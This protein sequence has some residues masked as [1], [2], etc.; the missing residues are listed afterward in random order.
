VLFPY[1]N[2][3]DINNHPEHGTSRWVINFRDWHLAAAKQYPKAYNKILHEV[4]PERDAN[5]RK[6]Y[7]DYWWQYA[8]KRPAMVQAIASLDRCIVMTRHTHTVMP[9]MVSTSQVFSEATVVFASSDHALLAFLSGALHYWWAIE[10]GS[11]IKGDLRYTATDIFETLVRPQFT[12]R[13]RVAGTHLNAYRRNLM[14]TRNMGLTA[15]YNLVHSSDC[16]DEDIVE[17]RRIHEE[18]DKATVEAYGWHDLLDDSGQTLPT[19]P[20]FESFP[21][22]HGIHE[23]DQGPRYT[24]GLLA[25]TEI[26]D[27]LRQ[28]NHQAFADEVHLG[29]HKKSERK[30]LETYPNMP[31]PSADAVRRCKEQLS[32]QSTDFGEGAEGALF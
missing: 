19:D 26:I 5:N 6:V 31:S 28:L 17:L 25:R 7:R 22:D 2:G 27:R 15:T 14:L 32:V 13:L 1:L 3:Q 8:E 21:L 29:L 16:Q 4:K 11:T 10:H 18:I 12:E 23:T 24:I 20:T 30:A 9:A